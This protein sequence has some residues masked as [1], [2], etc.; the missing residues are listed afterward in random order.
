MNAPF[1]RPK[2][3][4]ADR[5][6]ALAWA[7]EW[8]SDCL[9]TFS[10]AER[11]VGDLLRLFEARKSVFGTVALR[12]P[13]R[14]AFVE[15]RRKLQA[16]GH[17]K[18]KRRHL[19]GTL[20]KLEAAFEWRNHLSHGELEMWVGRSNQWLLTLCHSE[21]NC[22]G[23][24]RWFAYPVGEAEAM[25]SNLFCEVQSFVQRADEL[26]AALEGQVPA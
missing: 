23:P 20:G 21:G 3:T 13:T 14:T 4:F 12:A 16:K 2:L 19:D 1:S 18:D 10:V 7:K 8:K 6:R 9:D 25:Q 24:V 22:A 5:A 15:L 17:C 26:S 11:K